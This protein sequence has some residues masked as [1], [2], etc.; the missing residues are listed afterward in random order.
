MGNHKKVLRFMQKMGLRSYIR[1][2]HRCNNTSSCRG[3]SCREYPQ[4][5]FHAE[6]LTQIWVTDITQYRVA[7]TKMYVSTIKDL[8]NGEIVAH[9]TILHNDKQLVKTFTYA[10]EK[11]KD[12][13]GL[14]VHSD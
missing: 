11:T 1:R 7:D 6:A 8:C 10:F 13:I 14:I 12:V 3:T 4:C 2:K 9:H 5:N